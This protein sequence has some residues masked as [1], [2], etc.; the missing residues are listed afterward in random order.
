MND[1]EMDSFLYIRES[2][3]EGEG[4]IIQGQDQDQ[5]SASFIEDQRQSWHEQDSLN[6][7]ND[8]HDVSQFLL[9]MET[10][11]WS[12]LGQNQLLSD[13]GMF[14]QD[15]PTTIAS[16][17]ATGS[18]S[19]TA[20][21]STIPNANP[22][23]VTPDMIYQPNEKQ[24]I[25]GNVETPSTQ[26]NVNRNTRMSTRSRT[27]QMD[28]APSDDD[29][30]PQRDSNENVEPKRKTQRSKKLYC[31]CQQPYDGSP[32]VQCDSCQEWFHC[33]CVNL[34]PDE[35]EDIEWTCDS[36]SKKPGR[37]T[38]KTK[39]KDQSTRSR[40]EREAS[41]EWNGSDEEDEEIK[42]D[43]KLER[44][45]STTP[46]KCLLSTCS[47]P[48][49][50]GSL[51]CSEKCTSDHVND[52]A[53]TRRTSKKAQ[54]PESNQSPPEKPR[55]S[56]S[57]RSKNSENDAVRRNVIKS[58]TATLKSLIEIAL[59]KD[60]T[61]FANEHNQITRNVQSTDTPNAS[62]DQKSSTSERTS[63]SPSKEEINET[64]QTAEEA[65]PAGHPPSAM[66]IAE[67]LAVNVENAMFEHLAEPHPKTPASKP[68]ICGEKYKGKFRS[69]L[70]NLKDKANEIFQ[71]RVITGDLSP[72][73]LVNMS[74]EDMANPELKSMSETLRQKSIKNSVLQI[75]NM[76]IIKK[77]HKGDI[78][79]MPTKENSSFLDDQVGK[80]SP[81]IKLDEKKD[82][83]ESPKSA[84][85][86]N[87]S[88]SI[89]PKSP[90][91]KI[92]TLDDILARMM[93]TGEGEEK[94][95][96]P[97]ESLEDR[98]Q[99]KR[100]VE[101]DMEKLLGDEDVQLEF[102]SDDEGLIQSNIKSDSDMLTSD[103]EQAGANAE[104]SS[105]QPKSYSL[106]PIWHGKTIMQQVAEF[107]SS[108]LQIGGR[109]LAEQE[110]ADIL[111][112]T[113]WIE[114]R[115]PTDRVTDYLTQTQFSSNKEL[116]LIEIKRTHTD[117]QQ[118]A[119]NLLKYFST[120]NRY[121]VVARNMP[122]IK[123]F[124]I[125]PLT[126]QE[127]LP[128]CLVA[129]NHNLPEHDRDR[130]MLLGIIVL[131]KK[132]PTD[133]RRR[134]ESHSNRG[135][136]ISS[137]AEQALSQPQQSL[138]NTTVS[139]AATTSTPDLSSLLQNG[140]VNPLIKQLLSNK[141]IVQLLAKNQSSNTQHS[142]DAA[143]QSI[144]TGPSHDAYHPA[145]NATMYHSNVQ[146]P[147]AFPQ[148]NPPTDSGQAPYTQYGQIPT[149][150]ASYQPYQQHWNNRNTAY[151]SPDI[152][153]S[154]HNNARQ[155]R[156]DTHNTGSY[157]QYP[158]GPAGMYPSRER[159]HNR[160]PDFNRGRG[161]AGYGHNNGRGRRG[162]SGEHGRPRRR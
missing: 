158:S 97:A 122:V 73:N 56:P 48:A 111:S 80:K 98:E 76:P 45:K 71:L 144:P 146:Q 39:T 43:R 30:N 66:Q 65:K 95:K 145:H 52:K 21:A 134:S 6:N 26:S 129:L 37:T 75:Q 138:V 29:S 54:S 38:G 96:R 47:K 49:K 137:H 12:I 148:S 149:E 33:S 156:W 13:H 64:K 94:G 20:V 55:D 119:D 159:G 88:I 57:N 125:I 160:P 51:F 87:S 25:L 3:Y 9:P 4:Q 99:K 162:H 50:T 70:Y 126:A 117:G 128:D 127:N 60:P 79:M 116:I 36:C 106:L 74:A 136:N 41:A 8:H 14:T 59:A 133:P 53:T 154:S 108:A 121:G 86:R 18:D 11:D 72:E 10:E 44:R 101:I 120:R 103:Q 78:I 35:A 67:Q 46:G 161:R 102:G 83:H 92:D 1:N 132:I 28:N 139:Q 19:L 85:G 7:L 118:E 27:R 124:Y 23:Y 113:I 142:T 155:S 81:L 15:K 152:P 107:E 110:W 140:E 123:D 42:E 31:I 105:Q 91:A 69:L 153:P 40:K 112:P 135:S 58:L 150:P 84:N 114:G 24:D 82:E 32:M 90:S 141:D 22:G 147:R 77:T 16:T 93:P 109:C 2:G 115:I 61:L 5:Q 34:D 151:S 89:T 100:K 17:E 68:Q 63:I 131:N 143:Y 130:D 157:Q 62:K 104:P